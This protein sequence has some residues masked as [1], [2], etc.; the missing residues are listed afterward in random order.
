[1]VFPRWR[2]ARVRRS[3]ADPFISTLAI[4]IL[5]RLSNSHPAH[6]THPFRA[7]TL[8]ACVAAGV[9]LQTTVPASAQTPKRDPARE[10]R[11]ESQLQV[12]APNAVATF[13]AAT[14]AMDKNDNAEA[15]R[16]FHDVVAEAPQFSP[17]IRRLGWSLVE[18]GQ[19]EV[20]L[21]RLEQAVQLE[22]SPENLSSLAQALA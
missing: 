18:S 7:L 4:E 8:F 15:A 20:G 21:K 16:L 1:M 10:S 6:M 13:R 17:A 14:A 5:A 2:A 19:R 3:E 12:I 22:R 11:I 9:L